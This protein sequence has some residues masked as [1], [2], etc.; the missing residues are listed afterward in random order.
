MALLGVFLFELRVYPLLRYASL[1]LYSKTIH[2]WTLRVSVVGHT[3][4][5][6]YLL[7]NNLSPGGLTIMRKL[8]TIGLVL[9]TILLLWG[10]KVAVIAGIDA[11]LLN[12]TS[13]GATH[14]ALACVFGYILISVVREQVGKLMAYLQ[15]EV[16]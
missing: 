3:L 2:A 12:K 1:T 11:M 13:I 5:I 10:I 7:N 14:L 15:G 9:A 16:V 8:K 4:G 6:T